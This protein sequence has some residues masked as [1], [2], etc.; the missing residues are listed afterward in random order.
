MQAKYVTEDLYVMGLLSSSPKFQRR[1]CATMLLKH[2]L[3]MADSEGRLCY[4]EATPMG[5]SVYQRLGWEIIDRL[6]LNIAS[7]EEKE[8]GIR[9]DVV[10]WT[11]MRKP[12]KTSV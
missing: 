2:V 5:L 8:K 3:D 1:G 6:D 10:N 12:Q 7:E 9:R 11:L 4:I